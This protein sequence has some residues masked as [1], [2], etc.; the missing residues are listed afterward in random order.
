MSTT[1]RATAIV[2]CRVDKSK[3]FLK[4]KVRGCKHE[5]PFGE[6]AQ[7]CPECG[8]KLWTT[9]VIPRDIYDISAETILG[10]HV[11]FDENEDHL[12][13]AADFTEDDYY[14]DSE[15]KRISL[16]DASDS[17]EMSHFKSQMQRH[18]LWDENEVG[19]WVF[20]SCH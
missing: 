2:G 11:F 14:N 18:G 4:K 10:F 7:F 20:L 9:L 1:Y 3:V 5:T 8:V 16:Q 19:I 17:I 15:P 12:F 6:N 13:I